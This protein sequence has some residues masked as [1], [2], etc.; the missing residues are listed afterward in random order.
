MSDVPEC[1]GYRVGITFNLKHK[2]DGEHEDEQA[3]YDSLNTIEAIGKAIN[4]AGCET[5][6]IEA[7]TSLPKK[8][9]TTNLD[10]V[11]NIAE[12]KGGRGREAQ[13]PSILNLYSIPFT[14]SDETTLCIAL[15]KGL[16]KR[17]VRSCRIK[18]PV[19]F[20]WKNSDTEIPANLHFPVI[21]KPNAEGS[22]KGLIGNS[23]AKSRKE[24][25]ELL[26]EKWE[27]YRQP[28]LVEEYITGREFTVG[29]LGNGGEKRVFRPMEIII[30]PE[31][32]PDH[33]R[34]YSFHVKTNY[35]KYVKYQCPA[36]L[37]P[38]IEKKMIQ[39]SAKIYD[40]LE[41]RDFARIDFI[42]SEDN[43][44]YF[45]EINPLPGLAPGY[46]DYPML[47]EYNGL[48]YDELVKEILNSGLK[49][50]GMSAV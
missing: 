10:I 4:K 25:V 34:I 41:C 18:T 19:F 13:V 23:V 17:L 12:G 1:P 40:L 2:Q 16:T 14:G 33:S 38:D 3:E 35:Q 26:N 11:F 32:N 44:I 50:Y 24:L 6:F 15:D 42:L 43:E 5:V 21:V 48:G 28:L 37:N 7:D 29:I 31:G 20:V 39:Y 36:D 22:S 49:R 47:A 30:S 46:S 9:E 45:I 8:L 27:R